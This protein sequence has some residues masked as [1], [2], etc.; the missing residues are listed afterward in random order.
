[1]TTARPSGTTRPDLAP[2]GHEPA[3]GPVVLVVHDFYALFAEE[4]VLAPTVARVRSDTP[5][6]LLGIPHVFLFLLFV[7]SESDYLERYVVAPEID[8][9]KIVL[10]WCVARGLLVT[11]SHRLASF[12]LAPDEHHRIGDDLYL[13][14]L[15]PVLGL[16]RPL[17]KTPIYR[18]L[19]A[20]AEVF[21]TVLTL[22]APNDHVEE[23][24]LLHPLAG[25][26]L[27]G[28]VD[29]HPQLTD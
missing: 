12:V 11:A 22:G 20:L 8:V 13:A 23:V 24:G 14:P 25:A 10:R 3:Q 18:Y 2:L 5:C 27:V 21:G 1:M 6:W 28:G 9:P 15:A 17:V 29:R 4:A 26:V 19:P 16:P 7:V